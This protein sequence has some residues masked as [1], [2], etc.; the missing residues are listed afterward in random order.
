[1]KNIVF[2]AP[3]PE[4]G[5]TFG[6]EQRIVNIDNLLGGFN[7]IYLKISYRKYWNK[8][9]RITDNHTIY[10]LNFI[11]HFFQIYRI[12]KKSNILYFHSI[13][14]IP[15]IIFQ[16]LFLN[17]N[18]ITIVLDLHG[19]VPEEHKFNNSTSL[20][21]IYSIIER[22]IFSKVNRLIFVTNSMRAFYINKYPKSAIIKSEIIPIFSQNVFSSSE[23]STVQELNNIVSQKKIVFIYSGK[24]N[25]WQNVPKMLEY[26]KKIE[27]NHNFVFIILSPDIDEFQTL[28]KRNNLDSDKILL[29]SVT[30][31][32]LPAYYQ[33]AHYGFILRDDHILNRVANPTKMV[34][35]LYYGI[36]P[37]VQ[38]AAIGDFLRLDYDHIKVESITKFD[39][40]T[41]KST[42]NMQIATQIVESIK[43]ININSFLSEDTYSI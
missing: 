4:L 23:I 42:K 38:F 5:P 39:F 28:I 11:F 22:Y 13:S 40:K 43:T 24:A 25:K 10:K 19:S 7:R 41:H 33:I 31:E 27:H 26:F 34:E 36:T 14:Y 15:T 6:I 8:S 32:E 20:Y 17:K 1:M 30:P 21:I 35:Y 9:I 3:Y 12:L 18:K 29:K 16:F 37:I 2:I